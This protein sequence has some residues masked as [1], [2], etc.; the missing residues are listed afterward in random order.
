LEA[1][2]DLI[3]AGG[4]VNNAGAQVATTS[5]GGLQTLGLGV[6]FAWQAIVIPQAVTA[7]NAPP[8]VGECEVVDIEGSVFLKNPSVAGQYTF[9]FGIYIS[10]FDTRTGT[11]SLRFPSIGAPNADA[12]RDDWL[13]LRAMTLVLPVTNSVTDSMLLELKLAL[14]HRV[15]LGGGEALHVCIDISQVPA[16]GLGVMDVVPFFRT[17]IADVT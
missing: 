1:K 16:G 10:K 14:P 17:R 7:I 12:A 13:Y 8:S 11:W 6:Q 3:I 9:G 4:G 15:I 5:W 2:W